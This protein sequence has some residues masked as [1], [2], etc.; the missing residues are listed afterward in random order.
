M[1]KKSN[2]T[3]NYTR[4][5][6]Q[7]E[8]APSSPPHGQHHRPPSASTGMPRRRLL[9]PMTPDILITDLLLVLRLTELRRQ[10]FRIN[11]YRTIDFGYRI[12]WTRSGEGRTCSQIEESQQFSRFGVPR[13]NLSFC[14][15]RFNTFSHVP[16]RQKH[17]ETT[18]I[19][20]KRF[21][22]PTRVSAEIPLFSHHPAAA[23]AKPLCQTEEN[24]KNR[25]SLHAWNLSSA[26]YIKDSEISICFRLL[27]FKV[28]ACV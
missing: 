27:K 21:F 12:D 3:E 9:N 11:A 4:A 20:V 7:S 10:F 28:S 25:R 22:S 19:F 23:F 24:R 1:T 13:F 26:F 5:S 16:V 8:L 6:E 15:K 17:D 2:V 14:V 18:S